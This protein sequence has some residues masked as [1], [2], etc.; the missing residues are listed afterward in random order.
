MGRPGNL[1]EVGGSAVL[2]CRCRR[3]GGFGDGRP[4]KVRYYHNLRSLVFRIT[5]TMYLGCEH[6][7]VRLGLVC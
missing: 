4:A 3:R 5:N 2:Y 7:S 1:S 6:K